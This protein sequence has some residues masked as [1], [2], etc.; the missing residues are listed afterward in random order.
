MGEDDR[1]SCHSDSIDN[2][3]GEPQI[4]ESIHYN[5][6][7][8]RQKGKGKEAA[9]SSWDISAAKQSPDLM[10][11]APASED[12]C[13]APL[14]AAHNLRWYKGARNFVATGDVA[15][16]LHNDPAET[17]PPNE[18]YNTAPDE[19]SLREDTFPAEASSSKKDLMIEGRVAPQG[20]LEASQAE[21]IT[22][23]FDSPKEHTITLIHSIPKDLADPYEP[24]SKPDIPPMHSATA[25][26]AESFVP[27]PMPAKH[28]YPP[29]RPSA[30]SSIATSTLEAAAPE[31]PKEDGH[32]IALKI[33]SGSKVLRA[34]V[35]IRAC[36]RTAIIDEARAYYARWARDDP[37]SRMQLSTGCDLVLM[38]LDMDGCDMDLSTYKVEDLSF[39]IGVVEGTGIPRFTVQ[40]SE[41]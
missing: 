34:L 4:S 2:F 41:I 1:L 11:E 12:A 31:A 27:V 38:S 28:D 25:E 9:A 21:P 8:K 23:G 3:D 6:R 35:F 29:T 15:A 37:M 17:C 26:S 19:D 33:R 18:P 16:E 32:T 14:Y 40:I 36:T 39:L 10:D 20:T 22:K 13:S 24:I 30:P 7:T 5:S